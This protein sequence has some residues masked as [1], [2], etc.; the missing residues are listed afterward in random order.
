MLIC[1]ERN[2]C[3]FVQQLLRNHGLLV[4]PVKGCQV[5]R[6]G[7]CL[8]GGI[9]MRAVYVT[10]LPLLACLVSES[11]VMVGGS[12]KL[13]ADSARSAYHGLHLQAVGLLA[14]RLKEFNQDVQGC[15]EE[16]RVLRGK[17]GVIRIK[18][19]ENPPHQLG[20]IFLL[21]VLRALLR[22]SD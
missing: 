22:E 4:C 10:L 18:N 14:K 11:H 20:K 9:T 17:V 15:L 1:S 16:H 2:A 13:C 7:A 6:E 21:M 19:Y 12:R 8:H 5:A 3:T